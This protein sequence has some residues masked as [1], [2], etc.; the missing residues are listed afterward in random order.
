MRGSF[1]IGLLDS[2]LKPEMFSEER[3]CHSW[4]GVK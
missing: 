1:S 4:L 3:H 2:D